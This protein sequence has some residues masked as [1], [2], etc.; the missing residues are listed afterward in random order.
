MLIVART[1]KRVR[2]A[3][4]TSD[5]DRDDLEALIEEAMGKGEEAEKASNRVSDI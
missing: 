5:E 4:E 3:D 1:K 2:Y